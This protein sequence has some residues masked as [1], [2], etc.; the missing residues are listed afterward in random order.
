MLCCTMSGVAEGD[1]VGVAGVVETALMVRGGCGNVIK[2]RNSSR[3]GSYICRNTFTVV[4]RTSVKG[5]KYN[6]AANQ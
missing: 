3:H 1:M 2:H 6:M 4:Y 5:M